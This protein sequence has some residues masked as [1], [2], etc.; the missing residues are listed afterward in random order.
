MLGVIISEKFD[1]TEKS[2]NDVYNFLDNFEL[3]AEIHKWDGAKKTPNVTYLS[4]GPRTQLL[5]DMYEIDPSTKLGRIKK[6][7]HQE[8]R[9]R[10]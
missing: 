3:T 5:H 7:I 4:L 6:I 9:T 2:S 8:I 1:G 10:T